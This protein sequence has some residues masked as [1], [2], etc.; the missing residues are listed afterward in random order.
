[1]RYQGSYNNSGLNYPSPDSLEEFKLVTN[2]YGA[3]YGFYAGSIFTAVT[4]SGTNE[5]HGTAWEFLRNDALNARNFFSASVPNPA[6][7]PVRRERRVPDS[8]EQ[9]I[10]LHLIPGTAHS[11]NVDRVVVSIDRE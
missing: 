10:R 3:E 7:E 6:P 8:E 9:G 11:G 2:S 4:R 1:M 5:L